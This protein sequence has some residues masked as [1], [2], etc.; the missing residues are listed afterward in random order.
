MGMLRVVIVSMIAVA[1]VAIGS[2]AAHA[3]SPQNPYRS[4]NLSGVNYGSMQWERAQQQ[5]KRSRPTSTTPGR[6][7]SRSG[8]LRRR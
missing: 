5:G 7:S 6:T 3:V 1:A 2:P 8:R 4:F